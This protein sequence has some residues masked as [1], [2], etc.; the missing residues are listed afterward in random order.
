M[1]M[2]TEADT[3]R[4]IRLKLGGCLRVNVYIVF[5]LLPSLP[6]SHWSMAAPKKGY[7]PHRSPIDKSLFSLG[8]HLSR[9]I[10]L[11]MACLSH[12]QDQDYSANHSVV[13]LNHRNR[14]SGWVCL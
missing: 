9:D 3:D 6:N 10:F 5:Q 7:D 4:S 1:N 8:E 12:L 2:M 14:L 11:T 13:F